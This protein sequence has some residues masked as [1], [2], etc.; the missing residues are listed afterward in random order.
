MGAAEQA[1]RD[2]VA[3]A[4]AQLQAATA[5]AMA[6]LVEA[7]LARALLRPGAPPRHRCTRSPMEALAMGL[8]CHASPGTREQRAPPP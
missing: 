6:G 3:A 8:R 4:M 2:Q 1:A 7:L 5:S